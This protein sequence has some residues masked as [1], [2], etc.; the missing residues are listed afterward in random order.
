V[1]TTAIG[2]IEGDSSLKNLAP[3]AES[4]QELNLDRQKSQFSKKPQ[5]PKDFNHL[6][7]L[8]ELANRWVKRGYYTDTGHAYKALIEG[9]TE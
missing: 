2:R 1:D 5:K 6:K 4:G 7:A 8:H 3:A 9:V